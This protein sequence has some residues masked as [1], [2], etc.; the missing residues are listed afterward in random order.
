[1]DIGSSSLKAALI[2]AAGGLH[3]HVRFPYGPEDGPERWLAALC[4][5]LE[6]LV[7][8]WNS[9]ARR[10]GPGRSGTGRSGKKPPVPAALVISGNGPTLV[11]V[12]EGAGRLESLPPVYWYDAPL[13]VEDP[14]IHGKSRNHGESGSYKESAGAVLPSLFLA[15]VLAFKRR[16]PGS[17]SRLRYFF[18]PQE[19]LAWR[20]GARPV[21]AIPHGGYEPRYWDKGQ[22]EALGLEREWFPPFVRMGTV[23]GRLEGGD[24]FSGGAAGERGG[25]GGIPPGFAGIPLV[26][27]SSDFIMALVGTNTLQDGRACDRTGSSEGLNLCLDEAAFGGE[28]PGGLRLLPGAVEGTW[29]LGAVIPASGKLFDDYR[30]TVSGR[31]AAALM[32][33]ILDDPSHPGRP[34]V[35]AMG[36]AFLEAL[37]ALEQSGRK[38]GELVLSGGQ[39]SDARWNRYKADLSGRILHVPEITD[40]ELAGNAVLGALVL[41][42]LRG[43]TGE[44]PFGERLREKASA[45]IRIKESYVPRK[46]LF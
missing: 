31:T 7:E 15:K 5:A 32:A 46:P 17:F 44:K 14:R 20:L 10:S 43:Q 26:A 25:G 35:E 39:A 4:A 27:A 28:A 8:A 40:A 24:V 16:D 11:P 19:W 38:A 29:N 36:R 13:H 21:T 41:E 1:V 12:I 22:C 6:R 34:V 18:S 45:M 23:M 3:G 33:E 37:G 42:D 2:D 30:R 9:G